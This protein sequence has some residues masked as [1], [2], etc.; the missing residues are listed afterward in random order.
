[1]RTGGS[2]RS[3]KD[4]FPGGR[5][6]EQELLGQSALECQ[7]DEV[8]ATANTELVE[9]V[10]DVEF[11]RALGDVELV[12]NFLVGLILKQSVEN[13]L[14]APAQVGY[15]VRLQATTLTGENGINKTGEQLAR[16][17]ETAIGDKR[18]SA[19]EL[20][21]RFDVGQQTFYAEA[22]QRIAIGFNVLLADNDE[23]GF[24]KTFN[25]VGKQR[26]G[27]R[28]GGVGVNDVDVRFGRFQAAHI[29]SKRRLQLL[30]DYFELGFCEN[31]LKFAQHQRVRREDAYCQF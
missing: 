31:A 20:V 14:F 10:G 7:E 4:P 13:F 25:Q 21:T 1:M 30:D 16:D 26:A 18:K 2:G 22:E 28:L 12:G 19:N 11:Y 3:G 17:P 27:C 8:C 9:Q 5:P 29:R 23:A 24:R 15:R 6:T